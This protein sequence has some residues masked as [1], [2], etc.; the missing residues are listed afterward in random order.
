MR[1]SESA[2]KIRRVLSRVIE[3][4]VS[5]IIDCLP[6]REMMVFECE[7]DMDDNP[8]AFY[9]YL[10]KRG[11][12]RKH[13]M[14][15]FVN[16]DK[17]CR[18]NYAKKNVTFVN[19]EKGDLRN[20]LRMRYYCTV[21]K[22][23]IFSHPYW[24][25]KRR[26]EQV[27]VHVGHGSPVKNASISDDPNLAKCFDWK[28]VAAKIFIPWIEKYGFPPEKTVICGYPRLD[29]LFHGDRQ[30]IMSRLFGDG[31]F[32]K[33]IICM[34]TYKKSTQKV[35]SVA[36]DKYSLDVL[37]SEEDYEALNTFL[38]ERGAH[39]IIKPHPLQLLD[40]LR[41]KDSSNIH[42]ITNRILLEKHIIFYQLLGCC[43]GLITDLSSVIYDFLLL[44]RP[45][46]LLSGNY[47]KY[48]RGFIVDNILDFLPGT[49]IKNLDELKCFLNSCITNED[50]N[51]E[52]RKSVNSIVNKLPCGHYCED[53]YNML[54]IDGMESGRRT[55]E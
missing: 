29:E 26:K 54:F 21:P 14:V 7:S 51:S 39:L 50:S 25:M 1:L 20:R 13:K 43:D 37:H 35:D 48:V 42:Y 22:Y 38:Q 40:G 3:K 36:E 34:P 6:T 11:W 4:C 52:K 10:L 24:F 8:R 45:I 2:Q 47:D 9:E 19:R 53:L 30:T 32:S 46:G 16:D 31:D 5:I 41:T 18:E 23:Y 49:E 33:V 28:L 12:N 55:I 27:I 15:W 44:D 17:Y